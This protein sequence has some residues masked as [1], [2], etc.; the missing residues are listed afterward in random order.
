M[1]VKKISLI[2]QIITTIYDD[3]EGDLS[4]DRF[5]KEHK[6]SPYHLLRLFKEET[7]RTLYEFVQNA[8]LQYA[9]LSLFSYPKSSI[10]DIATLSGYASH[11]SFIRAF[12]KRF[13]MT[14]MQWKKSHLPSKR[15]LL[16]TAPCYVV[17]VATKELLYIR[18]Q[19]YETL[20]HNW[21]RV[22]AMVHQNGLQEHK[23]IMILE[24][25]PY[26]HNPD[27]AHYIVAMEIEN[28]QLNPSLKRLK[29]K[30]FLALRYDFEGSF[31]E[32]V[33]MIKELYRLWLPAS[34]YQ[35]KPH[36]AM[37]MLDK[38]PFYHGYKSF[39][40]ALHLPI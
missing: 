39:K 33:E 5:S 6:I 31:K 14:P 11:V 28:Q 38:N 8:R 26:L 9:A 1:N 13:L 10:A 24:D 34:G 20:Q 40:V 2:Q 27:E 25:N 17:T 15:D 4:L 7:Q 22:K 3:I 12:K 30:E 18:G 32:I 16:N 29:S 37:L 23:Q 35:L 36:P 21:Q 19:G